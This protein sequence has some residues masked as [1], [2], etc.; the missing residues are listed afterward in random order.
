LKG[1]LLWDP[2]SFIS[3]VLPLDIGVY[4]ILNPSASLA[5]NLMEK[6]AGWVLL[7]QEKNA[8]LRVNY[9]TNSMS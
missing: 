6:V 3:N 2:F 7:I 1:F 8:W 5:L 9:G 4:L